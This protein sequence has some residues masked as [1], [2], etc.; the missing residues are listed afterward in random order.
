MKASIIK[1]E[2]QEENGRKYPGE[3]RKAGTVLAAAREGKYRR[4][5]VLTV[6]SLCTT[7]HHK[8]EGGG[9]GQGCVCLNS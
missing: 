2:D 5:I 3:E 9:G 1:G 8:R 4:D 7:I 6:S